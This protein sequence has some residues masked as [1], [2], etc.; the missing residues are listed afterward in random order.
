MRNE[1]IEAV[2]GLLESLELGGIPRVVV[3]NKADQVEA[4]ESQALAR[5]HDGVAV[6]A[7]TGE[8]ADK[9]L[10]RIADELGLVHEVSELLPE[11]RFGDDT[12]V[13]VAEHA[14]LVDDERRR[15]HRHV[16][17]FSR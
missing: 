7:V 12:D 2:E 17:S 6:S 10:E 13:P 14:A 16:Q 4:F 15:Q 1:K 3:F 8:G 5:K 9:L 11:D